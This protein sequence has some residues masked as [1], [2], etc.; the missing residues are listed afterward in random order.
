MWYSHDDRGA[1]SPTV[2]HYGTGDDDDERQVNLEQA[3]VSGLVCGASRLLCVEVSFA[4][5]HVA[6]M[7][8]LVEVVRVGSGGCAVSRGASPR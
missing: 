5:Q 2:H 1:A 7:T 4:V 3:G 8:E 6:Q